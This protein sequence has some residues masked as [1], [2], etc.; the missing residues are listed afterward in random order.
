MN[1]ISNTVAGLQLAQIDWV[2]LDIHV[3]VKFLANA[4]GLAGFPPTGIHSRARQ[5][6]DL[7]WQCRGW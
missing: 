2:V 7:L 5:G 1:S 3:A 4:L 6:Y